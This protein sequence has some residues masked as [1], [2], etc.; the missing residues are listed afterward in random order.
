LQNAKIGSI[1]RAIA[2]RGERG[3]G[4]Y[5]SAKKKRDVIFT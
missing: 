2:R 5:L 4:V 3:I 1:A